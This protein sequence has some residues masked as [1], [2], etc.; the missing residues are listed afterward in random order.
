MIADEDSL[1]TLRVSVATCAAPCK[2]G[3]ICSFPDGAP[4]GKS[5]RRLSALAPAIAARSSIDLF[6]LRISITHSPQPRERG[7]TA[8]CEW[9]VPLCW[10]RLQRKP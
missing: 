10:F 6:P 7:P 2:G 3:E 4:T 1:Y 5:G 8:T 9:H